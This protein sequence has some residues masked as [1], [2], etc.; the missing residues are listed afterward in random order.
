MGDFWVEVGPII[1]VMAPL[2]GVPLT[3]IT[4]YLRALRDQQ[5]SWHSELLRRFEALDRANADLCR[6]VD[7]FE[8]DYTT[9]EEWL[10]ECLHARRVLENLTETTVRLDATMTGVLATL[11]GLPSERRSPAEHAHRDTH[12][13]CSSREEDNG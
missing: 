8:R 2:V 13:T 10:R 5:V 1:A 3:V 4:F 7:E 11:R 6:H 9:K 12:E